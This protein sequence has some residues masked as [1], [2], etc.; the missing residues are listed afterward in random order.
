MPDDA[1][2]LPRSFAWLFLAGMALEA[3]G[4]LGLRAYYLPADRT[5]L[6]HAHSVV[7]GGLIASAPTGALRSNG[8]TPALSG[9]V[10]DFL[11]QLLEIDSTAD[12]SDLGGSIEQTIL[13]GSVRIERSPNTNYPHFVYRPKG[14]RED[15]ALTNASS[16]AAEVAPVV[17][18][19]RHLVSPGNV[20]IVEEPE[21]HMHP[22][23]QVKFM[24]E[25]AAIVKSGVRVIV[26]MHSEWMTEELGNIV[27]RSALPENE[28]DEPALDADQVGA[29]LFEPTKRPKGSIVSEVALDADGQYACGFDDVAV[30]LHN[31]WAGI[32]SRI[33]GHP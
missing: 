3:F 11:E 24:R 32:T 10:A 22:A 19:L 28:G 9:V 21:S 23:M 4:P 26:T 5:G 27:R 2:G 8:R 6:M 14:W 25:L 33:E 30:A 1:K 20:L 16:M 17:L 18:Y 31:D 13:G 29:W 7:V 15:L 12:E